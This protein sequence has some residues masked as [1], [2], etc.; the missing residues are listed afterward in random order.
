MVPEGRGA[1]AAEAAAEGEVVGWQVWREGGAGEAAVVARAK[2]EEAFRLR[3]PSPCRP[4]G[5][6]E[7]GK[8]VVRREV[9]WERCRTGSL[10]S[11][12]REYSRRRRTMHTLLFTDE[13]RE[14]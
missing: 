7:A 14:A 4:Q 1:A 5:A 3:S 12:K 8:E 13:I 6:K 9:A 10:V 2:G 11:A